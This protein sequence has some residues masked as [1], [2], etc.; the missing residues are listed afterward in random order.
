[1]ADNDEGLVQYNHEKWKSSRDNISP[2]LIQTER[3]F[4]L[5]VL[6]K[7]LVFC[8]W[9]FF[10]APECIINDGCGSQAYAKLI[11]ELGHNDEQL[12]FPNSTATGRQTINTLRDFYPYS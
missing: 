12:K 10:I 9:H 2:N 3:N 4:K 7:A 5:I 8:G 11:A 6:K 1:M